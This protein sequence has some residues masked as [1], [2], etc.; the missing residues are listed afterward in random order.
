MKRLIKSLLVLVLVPTIATAKVVEVQ[1]TGTGLSKDSAIESGLLQALRQVHGF[2]VK[3]VQQ[4]TQSQVKING[5]S[6]I[7]VKLNRDSKI[8]AKGQIAG[9]DVL[10]STCDTDGCTADL[11]VRVHQ[12]DAPGLPTDNRR[13][14]AIMPFTGGHEFRKL[15]TRQ[16]QEQ[17]VQ[18]RRFAVLDR[19][20]DK[21][22]KTEKA[23]WQ[24]DNVS[25]AEKAK[26]GKVL[27]LDYILTGSIEKAKVSRWTTNIAITGETKHHVR[28]NATVRYQIIAIATRQIKWSDTVSV[29]LDNVGS[30]NKGAVAIGQKISEDVLQ[31]IYPLRVVATSNGEVILNQGG[32]T[33]QK[34]RFY[35][36]YSLGKDVFDPYTNE[37][38]GKSETKIAIVKISRLEAKMA[39]AT[40]VEGKLGAIKNGFIARAV[41][42]VG[43]SKAKKAHIPPSNLV[44]PK[45]GG[46]IL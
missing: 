23:L 41:Q 42:A 39:Y 17:L 34:G 4:S 22:Y 28:T 35:T 8:S 38:L 26:M 11:T 44:V 24:S 6:D 7:Q 19:E 30:L 16:V 9:Y 21:E 5:K 33:L 13:R 10:D 15:V 18:S 25:I 31:N 1:V 2:D 27:G 40:V 36:I 12:Y 20:H 43:K 32:K 46:V 3:S 45:S 37:S 29:T 14:I